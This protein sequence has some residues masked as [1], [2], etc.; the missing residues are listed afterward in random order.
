MAPRPPGGARL[1]G[2]LEDRADADGRRWWQSSGWLALSGSAA[3]VGQRGR[4][5]VSGGQRWGELPPDARWRRGGRC[6]RR[7][8]APA[9]T[10]RRPHAPPRALS[11]RRVEGQVSHPATSTPPPAVVGERITRSLYTL[12]ER[13]F[14]IR[15]GHPLPSETEQWLWRPLRALNPRAFL[16][17]PSGRVW[18]H[19]RSGGMSPESQHRLCRLGVSSGFRCWKVTTS[20]RRGHTLGGPPVRRGVRACRRPPVG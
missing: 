15:C 17:P 9:Q 16:R 10:L 3:A 19:A 2:H 4:P 14:E 11:A 6:R 13:R 7:R 8:P 18:D 12:R 5:C 1:A 20:V